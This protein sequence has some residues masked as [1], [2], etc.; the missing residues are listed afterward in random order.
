MLLVFVLIGCFTV[1]GEAWDERRAQEMLI[2][3]KKLCAILDGLLTSADVV[4]LIALNPFKPGRKPEEKGDHLWHFRVRKRA[5]LKENDAIPKMLASLK[6]SMAEDLDHVLRIAKEGG[7]VFPIEC[8]LPQHGF[9]VL[10]DGKEVFILVADTCGKGMILGLGD[11][12][13]TFYLSGSWYENIEEIFLKAGLPPSEKKFSRK[14]TNQTPMPPATSV[15][16]AADAP[17]LPAAAA[18]N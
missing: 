9:R 14:P 8:F 5:I 17:A 16:P 15:P 11:D 13:I 18:A 1:R 6:A 3:Q 7:D 12:D 10:S 4:E 2:E